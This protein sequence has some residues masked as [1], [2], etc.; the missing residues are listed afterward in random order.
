MSPSYPIHIENLRS[1]V[2][3]ASGI[4]NTTPKRASCSV[5]LYTLLEPFMVAGSSL[6]LVSPQHST[7]LASSSN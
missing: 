1:H 4:Y 7:G 3:D 5:H 6:H 2:G